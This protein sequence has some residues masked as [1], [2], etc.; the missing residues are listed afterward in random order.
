MATFYREHTEP[1]QPGPEWEM[2]NDTLWLNS[3]YPIGD[4][5]KYNEFRLMPYSKPY[6][7]VVIRSEDKTGYKI[8]M[9]EWKNKNGDRLFTTERQVRHDNVDAY[10]MRKL[11]VEHD[12][13]IDAANSLYQ[14][15]EERY[16]HT[17]VKYPDLKR[18]TKAFYAD[19]ARLTKLQARHQAMTET[20][21]VMQG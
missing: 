8:A 14:E 13:T 15:L 21:A 1:V 17:D 18:H 10:P 12:D 19:I 11:L 9:T 20:L 3:P 5:G 2:V 16:G 4:Y 7:C 6:D